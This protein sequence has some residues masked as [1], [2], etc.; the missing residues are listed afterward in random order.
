MSSSY[1]DDDQEEESSL[2]DLISSGPNPGESLPDFMKRKMEEAVKFR[3]KQLELR[4]QSYSPVSPAELIEEDYVTKKFT[5]GDSVRL[6]EKFRGGLV[7]PTEG[8]VCQVS[9]VLDPP[10]VLLEQ[11]KPVHIYDFTLMFKT[12]EGYY[13][14]F[15]FESR[16]FSLVKKSK[17]FDGGAK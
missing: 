1:E 16:C 6:I 17:L 4:I 2:E 3:E 10:T 13:L 14:E 9:R 11:G 12:Q 15:P 7:I 8:M 5:V